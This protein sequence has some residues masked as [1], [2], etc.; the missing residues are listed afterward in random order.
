MHRCLSIRSYF[1]FFFSFF[2][3]FKEVFHIFI[4]GDRR[5]KYFFY[6][7]VAR[8]T[9]SHSKFLFF[10]P[11]V[12]SFHRWKTN[13]KIKYLFMD[14]LLVATHWPVNLSHAENAFWWVRL[15]RSIGLSLAITV[16]FL[17][18]WPN[19]SFFY[20]FLLLLFF[21]FLTISSPHRIGSS[22]FVL[23]HSCWP[24][25]FQQSIVDTSPLLTGLYSDDERVFFFFS[26]SFLT[27]S[28]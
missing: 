25:V 20:F 24:S 5:G 4:H 27:E 19:S 10:F 18:I 26:N 12:L 13:I 9:K 16:S 11:F 2:F 1:F 22:I 8:S 23:F 15:S 17:S 28:A 6:D 3:F 14:S 21:L 7:R